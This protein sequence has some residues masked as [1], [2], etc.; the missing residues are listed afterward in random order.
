M[1]SPDKTPHTYNSML[2]FAFNYG[3]IFRNFWFIF[4]I[5]PSRRHTARYFATRP[6]SCLSSHTGLSRTKI[7]HYT[8]SRFLLYSCGGCRRSGVAKSRREMEASNENSILWSALLRRRRVY[9][10]LSRLPYYTPCSRRYG[11]RP[12]IQLHARISL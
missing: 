8:L 6:Y 4:Q 5:N 3:I 9:D 1:H 12:A 7:L 11:E 10:I 2:S